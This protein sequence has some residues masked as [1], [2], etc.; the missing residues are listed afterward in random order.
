[1]LMRNNEFTSS[2]L[3]HN[4]FSKSKVVDAPI[5]YKL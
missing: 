2:D 1:M 3:K 4:V 5:T